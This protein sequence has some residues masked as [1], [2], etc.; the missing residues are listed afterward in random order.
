[1]I[2]TRSDELDS[3]ARIVLVILPVPNSLTGLLGAFRPC[4]WRIDGQLST[5]RTG[6]WNEVAGAVRLLLSYQVELTLQGQ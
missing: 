2:A 4:P 6:T 5:I 1:L 3:T